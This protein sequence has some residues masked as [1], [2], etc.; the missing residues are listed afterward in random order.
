[1]KSFIAIPALFALS[2][3]ADMSAWE[4]TWTFSDKHSTWTSATSMATENATTT[5]TASAE[6]TATA[7]WSEWIMTT[8]YTAPY[9]SGTSTWA[10]PTVVSYSEANNYTSMIHAPPSSSATT[11][12]SSIL[13]SVTSSAAIT[14]PPM[15]TIVAS[16]TTA[17]APPA[18]FTGAAVQGQI[19]GMG[20]LAVA[21]LALVL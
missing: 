19:V 17:S 1:M 18:T 4:F 16:S 6:S 12:V 21:G 7:S 3:V 10:V 14:P 15:S 8:S 13:S 20:A 9:S 11:V 5:A 2:A